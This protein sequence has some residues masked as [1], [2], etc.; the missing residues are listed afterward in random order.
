MSAQSLGTCVVILDSSKQKVLLGKRK[1]SYK[2]GYWGLPGG[3]L[4][5]GEP[6]LEAAS[7]EVFE[8]TSL[9]AEG[10]DFLGTIRE[11]QVNYDFVHFAFL[12]THFAGSPQNRE[13]NKC[14]GWEWLNLDH[15]PASIVP[16]HLEAVYLHLRQDPNKLKDCFRQ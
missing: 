1:N 2:S 11:Y 13:P 15:L 12:C 10:L 4:E 8:E 16:G 6:L 7:R 3:R 5:L 9:I 14:D